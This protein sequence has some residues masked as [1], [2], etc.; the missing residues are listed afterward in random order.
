MT[1]QMQMII[2]AVVAAIAIIG[3]IAFVVMKPSTTSNETPTATQQQNQPSPSQTKGSIESLIAAGNDV[4][5][6]ISYVDGSGTGVVFVADGKVRGDFNTKNSDGTQIESHMIQDGKF[7]YIWSGTQGTKIK[8]DETATASPSTTD[9]QQT[10]DLSKE[11]DLNCSAW[12]ADSSKFEVPQ[13][14]QF[15]DLSG[16][17]Q[18]QVSPG[19][20]NDSQ[21]STFCD[22]LTDPTAKAAC[23]NAITSGN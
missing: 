13:D 10:T 9:N 5:C 2:G 16:F 18:P 7:G 19:T 21:G 20:T 8:V 22:Q 6:N 12:S 3:A 17:T 23:L 4:T 1:K 14:V 11:V 15:S